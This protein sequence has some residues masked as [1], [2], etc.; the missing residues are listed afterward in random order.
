MESKNKA[1]LPTGGPY[2]FED[3]GT[4]V[5]R[6]RIGPIARITINRPDHGNMLNM[7]VR[8]EL[9]QAFRALGADPTIKIVILTG[10]GDTFSLC[11][12][13]SDVRQ[14]ISE[15]EPFHN[16]HFMLRDLHNLMKTIPQPIIAALNGK[17]T[18]GGLELALSC[19]FMVAAESALIGDCHPAGI[20]GGGLSQR[21]PAI[22]GARTTRWL[23]YTDYLYSAEEAMKMRLVQQVYPDDGF[24]DSVISLAQFP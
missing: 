3:G 13:G 2:K 6:K 1:R 5:L 24:Q 9:F 17:A 12:D 10:A 18:M 22:I 23:L 4:E 11:S 19:E 21:L 20:G 16:Y 15:S 8:R 14:F 7:A